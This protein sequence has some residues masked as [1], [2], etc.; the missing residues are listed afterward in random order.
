MRDDRMPIS[1]NAIIIASDKNSETGVE[2]LGMNR[3]HC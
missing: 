2:W 1:K 3:A